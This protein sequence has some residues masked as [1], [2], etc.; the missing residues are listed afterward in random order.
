MPAT[1]VFSASLCCLLFSIAT[2][3]ASEPTQ[4]PERAGQS[5]PAVDGANSKLSFIG[6]VDGSETF[7]AVGAVTV[8]L[9]HQFGLQFDGAA[10]NVDAGPIGDIGV[11]G[12]AAHLFWRDPSKGLI[13]GYTKLSHADVFGGLTTFSLAAEVAVYRGRL[14]VE[15]IA[16][17]SGGDVETDFLSIAMAKYYVTDQLALQIGHAYQHSQHALLMGAEW[18][19][20]SSKGA[21]TA[22]LFVNGHVTETGYS[23]ALAGLRFYFGQ[24]DK[25]LIR[26]HREDDPTAHMVHSEMQLLF[27][28]NCVYS[29]QH[30][31]QDEAILLYSELLP[32]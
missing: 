16:G 6:A 30:D 18:A 20:P 23:G 12:G 24:H 28:D 19:L 31:A 13:G 29:C 2:A 3:L 22:S 17:V 21:T 15:G 9:G 8:P 11:V 25:T 10:A 4:A 7:G 26:R 5:L 32:R 14:T 27:G 1:R